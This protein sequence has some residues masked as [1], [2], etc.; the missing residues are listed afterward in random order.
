MRS[1]FP[2]R[3]L[4]L[5]L[6]VALFGQG[7]FGGSSGPKG[8]DGG[9]YKTQDRGTT[10]AQKRVLVE[11]PKGVAIDDESIVTM[12]FDPQDNKAVYAGTAARGLLVSLDGGDSWRPAGALSS[13]RIEAVAVDPKDKCTVY[14]SQGNKIYKTENCG[15]DWRQAWFDPKTDKVFTALMVDWFNSTILYAGTSEGDILK[16]TDAGANW[17]VSKRAASPITSFA[18]HPNDS[19]IVYASTRGEGLWKT[20]DGGNTW[21]PIKDQ[22][23]DF[24]NAR[25]V[26]GVV[27]DALTPN[28]VYLV[29]PYGILVSRTDGNTWEALPVTSDPGDVDI[30]SFAVH[31]RE[32]KLLYYL[33]PNTLLLSGDAGATWTTQRLPSTRPASAMIVDPEDP[34]VIYVGMG[35]QPK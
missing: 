7:C 17:L 26:T 12:A 24:K 14:A 27:I 8:P 3:A 19:R 4:A 28:T 6:G 13:G 15:R 10:W 2:V 25:R 35:P 32:S 33:T 30:R 23:K 18:I 29:S 31:P 16:S 22:L 1:A 21:L 5:V 11:G 20:L 9:V 34:K